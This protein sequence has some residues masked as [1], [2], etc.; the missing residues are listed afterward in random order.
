MDTREHVLS[1]VRSALA[2]EPRI[3]TH[4]AA[5]SVSLDLEGILTLEGEVSSIAAKKRALRR[6]AAVAGVSGVV[7]RLRLK[8]EVAMGDREIRDHVTRAL[9]QE[10]AFQELDFHWL[11]AGERGVVRQVPTGKRGSIEVEVSDGVVVLNGRVPGLD[12][13]RL[14]GVLAWWIPGVR[15]VVNG[16]AVEPPE[17]D[18]PGLIEDAVKL[19]LEK[20]RLVNASEIRV[21]VR[22]TTVRLTGLLA[23]EA[24]RD[25]AENDAW[26]VF[27]VDDVINDIDVRR[28]PG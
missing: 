6:A 24:E 26:S 9:V 11:R 2:S 14:A 5:I 7:D 17:E 22:E 27:G 15:D 3:G 1:A 19:A 25:M 20:D 28:P 16:V 13:K 10:P 8:A 18:R 23:T 21:G 4:A 12:Y